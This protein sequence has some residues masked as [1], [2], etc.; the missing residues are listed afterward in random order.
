[1]SY[2]KLAN[3]PVPVTDQV[4]PKQVVNNAGGYTFKIGPLDQLERFLILGSM[5]GTYYAAPQKHT[6]QNIDNLRAVIAESPKQAVDLIADVS[7][8]G[9]SFSNAACIFALAVAATTAKAKPF[10]LQALPSVARTASHLFSFISDYDQMGGKW[11]RS[12]RTAIAL[13]YS[14]DVSGLGYQV[15]KYPNRAGWSHRDLLRLAHAKPSTDGHDALFGYMTKGTVSDKLPEILL[16]YEQVQAAKTEKEV[17]DLIGKHK[18]TWEFVPKEWTGSRDVW[19]ALLPNLPMTALLRNLGRMSANGL[20]SANGDAARYVCAKLRQEDQLKR[21]RV[22]P[23]SMLQ[24]WNVYGGGK[25]VKGSLTWNPVQSVLAAL[26]EAFIASY[27]LV[28]KLEKRVLWGQDVSASMQGNRIEN[29]AMNCMEAGAVLATTFA[30]SVGDD[31]MIYGFSSS[32]TELKINRRTSFKEAFN[33]IRK[34]NFGATNIGLLVETATKSKLPV[35]LFV[36]NTDNEVNSGAHVHKLVEQYRQV[37]GID[38]RMVVMGMTATPFTIADPD[39]QGMLD[40]VGL[41]SNA[42]NLIASFANGYKG[43][44]V[45]ADDDE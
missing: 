29:M 18:L 38:A 41:D 43:A 39:D 13:W 45:E 7:A 17:I 44:T 19:D 33:E 14:R 25:G 2:A 6:Q 22:H 9:R 11:G 40:V 16:A 23:L 4:A 5:G 32:L 34:Q 10:A 37:M 15:A 36:V 24:T 26:E 42:F 20:L 27:K 1:M 3:Q 30:N 31:F 12:L 21:A 28:E 8:K 35:D